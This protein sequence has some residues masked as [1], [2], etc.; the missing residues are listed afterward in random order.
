[1]LTWTGAGA[2]VISGTGAATGAGAAR[3]SGTRL[4]RAREADVRRMAKGSGGIA[5]VS[6]AW[7]AQLS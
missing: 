2:G 7:A 3:A 5:G 4:A 1:M 6:W